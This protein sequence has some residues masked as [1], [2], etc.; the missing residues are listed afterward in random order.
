MKVFLISTY[1]MGRQPFGLASPAAWLQAAGHEVMCADLCI[2]P[3]PEDAVTEA[4]LVALYLPM[5]T[6]AR[7]AVT[8]IER[9]RRLNPAARLACY[10]LYAPLNEA[11]LRKLGVQTILGGE[12]EQGLVELANGRQP[13][14]NVSLDR[15]QFR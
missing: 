7:L 12:F 14:Q 2:E 6:A 3:L 11:Y 8:V 13:R 15:L 5:H 4:E 9:V 1:E 10:G